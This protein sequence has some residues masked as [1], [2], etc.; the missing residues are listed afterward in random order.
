[1]AEMEKFK[2]SVTYKK[3]IVTDAPDAYA[4]VTLEFEG[5]P[6]EKTEQLRKVFNS[7]YNKVEQMVKEETNLTA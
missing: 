4:R 6:E 1:M 7:F 3:E 2:N 5:V